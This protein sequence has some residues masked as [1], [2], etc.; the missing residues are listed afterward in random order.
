MKYRPFG[1]TG[2]QVS[3]LGFG[4]MRLPVTKEKKIDEEEATQMIHHAI[5]R[6]VNYVDTAYPYHR[7]ESELVVGR[8]LQ[9]GYREKVKLATKM[10]TWAVE[11]ASD[12]DKFLNEQLEK[13]QVDQI[14]YYLLHTLDRDKWVKVRDLDVLDWGEKAVK[15]GRI[16]ALAFSFHDKYE[17]FEQILSDWDGWAFAQIQYNFMDIQHQAG[18]RGL[19]LAASKGIPVVIMEPLLGGRLVSA[20]PSVQDIWAAA[21]VQRSPVEWALQ[22]LWNQPEVT[23]VLSGMSAMQ[24]VKDNL[25]YADRSGVGSLS[26]VEME[27]VDRARE[28]Y[29]ALHEV[30]CT[31]C[32]YCQPC[33]QGVKI[34]QLFQ[35]YNTGNMYNMMD[36]QRRRYQKMEQGTRAED[37]VQCKE[38]EPKCPQKIE[39]SEWMPRLHEEFSKEV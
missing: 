8:A 17:T 20:P 12:F 36:R 4:C 35:M 38:C 13:L 3:A 11:E 27:L 33:P 24:H 37:C 22:W 32:G 16:G 30:P 7:G 39:I 21:P 26:E 25:D 1:D 10:P 9:G 2:F 14:D 19:K 29:K 15:D 18:T 5:G 31:R 34:P 23:T 6:G 28:A